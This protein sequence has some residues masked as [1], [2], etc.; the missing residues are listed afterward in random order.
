MKRPEEGVGDGRHCRE[1]E[2]TRLRWCGDGILRDE[3]EL[4]RDIM[5]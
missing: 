2:K 3:G 4:V 5:E 1:G